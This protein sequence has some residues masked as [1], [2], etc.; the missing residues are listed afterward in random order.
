[1]TIRPLNASEKLL[2]GPPYFGCG[3][4]ADFLCQMLATS[5]EAGRNKWQR[6]MGT[7]AKRR[8]LQRGWDR[9]EQQIPPDSNGW[10]DQGDIQLI[11]R[12]MWGQDCEQPFIGRIPLDEVW[13][14][15]GDYA[16]SAAIDTGAVGAGHPIRR[17]VGAVPHQVVW[18]AKRVVKGTKMVK[19]YCPMHPP[20]K[21]AYSGH[22]VKWQ[23]AA[24]CAK[25]I[26][27]SA[28]QAF[29]VLYPIGDWTEANLVRQRKNTVIRQQREA[30]VENERTI[31]RVREAR[32]K[33]RDEVV[34]RDIEIA[35]LQIDLTEC[36]EGQPE[37]I[38][39]DHIDQAIEWLEEQRP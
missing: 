30:I 29:V 16:V 18:W 24:K 9:F 15:I 26:K 35:R 6:E 37:D 3:L 14:A 31:S 19:H 38:L 36:Q 28:G 4:S 25:A 2:A 33:A 20:G 1:M 8:T 34:Q 12:A 32:D 5:N 17:W 11:R 27:G 21:R 7:G 13:E 23:D 22:W 39:N 10:V